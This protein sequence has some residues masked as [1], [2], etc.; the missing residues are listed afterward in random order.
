MM[1]LSGGFA[2]FFMGCPS[3]PCSGAKKAFLIVESAFV[4]KYRVRTRGEFRKAF[5]SV[6][7]VFSY[8]G[9]VHIL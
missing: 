7:E 2:A 9:I 5:A 8:N 3:V 4:V 6:P 1:G